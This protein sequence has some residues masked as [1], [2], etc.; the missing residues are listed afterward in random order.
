MPLS[1]QFAIM[2][3]PTKKPKGSVDR[4]ETFDEF[5]A[6]EGLLAETEDVAIK[7]MMADRIKIAVQKQR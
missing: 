6:K 5:L 2:K 7:E 3:Q 1:T 4:S